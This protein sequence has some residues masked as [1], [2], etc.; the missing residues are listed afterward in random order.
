M[1]VLKQDVVEL[2]ESTDGLSSKASDIEACSEMVAVL[3]KVVA[4]TDAMSACDEATSSSNIIR[5]VDLLETMDSRMEGNPHLIRGG[6]E[7]T[8]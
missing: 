8:S 3:E 2:L 5:T 6:S 7:G 4:L 1:K